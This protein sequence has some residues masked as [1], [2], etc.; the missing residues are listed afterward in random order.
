MSLKSLPPEVDALGNIHAHYQAGL[1]IPITDVDA[2]D[3]Q[4]DIS[5]APWFVK[6]GSLK[7]A[8]AAH[9]SD[10]KGRMLTLTP[11]ELKTHVP[12]SGTTFVV[13]DET[14]ATLPDARWE[15]RISARGT[16]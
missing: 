11:D 15:G 12:L 3:V 14:N 1:R 9:P 4:I 2:N 10:V 8:L 13:V 16:K 5:A 7:K 6:I